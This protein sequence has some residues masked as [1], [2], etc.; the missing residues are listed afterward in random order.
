[1]IKFFRKIRYDLMEKNRMGKY[2]KYAIGEIILVVIGILIALQINNWN[3]KRK[4]NIIEKEILT[5]I[6]H[7]IAADTLKWNFEFESYSEQLVYSNYI[8]N[9]FQDNTAYEKR[10]DTAFALISSAYIQEAEYIPFNNLLSK[11]FDV[12]KND[13]IKFYLNRYYDHSKHLAEI[14]E[15]F[16]NS[17]FYRQHIYPKYFISYTYGREAIP[18][19]YE[20]LK[21]NSE[22][23]IA[24]DY[25]INDA[26]FFKTWSEHKKEDALRLLGLIEEELQ[27]TDHD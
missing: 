17:K 14:E 3:E 22:F 10:L 27:F 6:Y 24:L 1:M 9:K 20:Q 4:I 25:T 21:T 11:G 7:S 23:K 18:I 2:V 5:S 13:S 8:K 16:E 12:L 19:N 15:Y 26:H